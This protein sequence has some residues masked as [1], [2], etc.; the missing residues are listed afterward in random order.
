MSLESTC[1]SELTENN[2]SKKS[3]LK[4]GFNIED[5]YALQLK[6][7]SVPACCC[8]FSSSPFPENKAGRD[9][10]QTRDSGLRLYG[11]KRK[12]VA[13]CYFRVAIVRLNCCSSSLHTA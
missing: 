9:Y 11:S 8:S 10:A 13:D 12:N 7:M 1:I 4:Q 2:A 6:G 5:G 3:C